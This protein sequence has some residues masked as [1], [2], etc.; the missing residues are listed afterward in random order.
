MNKEEKDILR[1]CTE[2]LDT[3]RKKLDKLGQTIPPV[4]F[5]GYCKECVKDTVH[6]S[7]LAGWKQVL[8]EPLPDGQ[9]GSLPE[10]DWPI[11]ACLSCGLVTRR[12][13]RKINE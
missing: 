3:Y 9:I 10:F 8:L 12:K 11:G 1:C 5:S 2:M 4:L 7:Y 6:I 13:G